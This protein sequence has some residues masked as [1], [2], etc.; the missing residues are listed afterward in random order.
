MFGTKL[1][2]ERTRITIRWSAS[3]HHTW[4]WSHSR[5][6][7]CGC[8]HQWINLP[9]EWNHWNLKKLENPPI[10]RLE[11]PSGKRGWLEHPRGFWLRKSSHDC[12]KVPFTSPQ[13][14]IFA[15]DTPQKIAVL[16]GKPFSKPLDFE[17]YEATWTWLTDLSVVVFSFSAT[18]QHWILSTTDHWPP[19]FGRSSQGKEWFKPLLAS[20]KQPGYAKIAIF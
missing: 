1:V 8:S 10:K 5:I 12:A 6:F 19:P 15:G 11:S 18:A 14:G 17:T 2:V 9:W 3:V 20:S 16:K 4:G 13:N 7:F